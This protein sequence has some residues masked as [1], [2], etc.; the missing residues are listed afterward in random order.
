MTETYSQRIRGLEKFIDDDEA[1]IEC[2]E[3]SG[4]V[5]LL[6]KRAKDLEDVLHKCRHGGKG[7]I[8]IDYQEEVDR[9]LA[10]R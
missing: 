5:Y 8:P 7:G 9:L 2:I 4:G 10:D 6:E 1:G 3:L